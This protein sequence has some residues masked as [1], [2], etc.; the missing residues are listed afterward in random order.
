VADDTI[1]SPGFD[2]R[3]KRP[4]GAADRLRAARAGFGKAM[5]GNA[6]RRQ[7]ATR[8][9]SAQ[10]HFRLD[11]QAECPS[12]GHGR[13]SVSMPRKGCRYKCAA[14]AFVEVRVTPIA[15]E[16]TNRDPRLG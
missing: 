1:E 6:G 15:D 4:P 8:R 11:R 14:V 12:A 9:P 16:A 7:P 10:R 13:S 3:G 5:Y 2:D